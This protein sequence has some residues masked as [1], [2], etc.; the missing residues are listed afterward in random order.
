MSPV[1]FAAG[2]VI[3]EF[4]DRLDAEGLPTGSFCIEVTEGAFIDSHAV[5]ALEKARQLGFGVTM[6]DFGVGYSCLAHR[7]ACRLSQSSSIGVSSL[8]R[9]K[10]QETP[11]CLPR[12][13]N[14]PMRKN[15]M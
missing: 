9:P 7:P 3:A 6:D 13:C 12:W 4:A 15:S 5:R 11:C 8:T 14:W 2:D 10:T 1:Q